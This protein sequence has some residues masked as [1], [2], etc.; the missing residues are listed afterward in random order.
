M[1]NY[2]GVIEDI[3]KGK[4]DNNLDAIS[5]AIKDRRTA[6][7]GIKLYSFRA[8]DTVK[9]NSQTRPKYLQGLTAE[10]VR[11]N[12]KRIV[13]KFVDETSKSRARKYGWGDFTTPISLVDKVDV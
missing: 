6:L 1:S 3:V 9:F 2:Y 7:N 11:V 10:V 4:F 12:Q 8:G 5:R 13:V